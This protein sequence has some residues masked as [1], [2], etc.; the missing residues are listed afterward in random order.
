MYREQKKKQKCTEIKER[1]NVPRPKK[2]TE[3]KERKKK[4]Q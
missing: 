4:V 2:K 1:K 3:I